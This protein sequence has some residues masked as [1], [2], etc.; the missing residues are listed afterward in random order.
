M[1]T[2]AHSSGC[3]SMAWHKVMKKAETQMMMRDELYLAKWT[4]HKYLHSRRQRIRSWCV[5]S[6]QGTSI[7]EP[8]HQGKQ[9]N[10]TSSFS[11]SIHTHVSQSQTFLTE[12]GHVCKP[13]LSPSLMMIFRLNPLVLGADTFQS[14][15]WSPRIKAFLAAS[16]RASTP[17]SD[18]GDVF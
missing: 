18:H 12:R 1:L 14:R 6:H 11:F 7:T 3:V 10:N 15:L 4:H 8:S 16:R 9:Q 13:H 2:V 5:C 17:R